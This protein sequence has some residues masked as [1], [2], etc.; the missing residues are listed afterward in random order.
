MEKKVF[1]VILSILILSNF[2]IGADIVKEKNEINPIV[3]EDYNNANYQLILENKQ[4]ISDRF[5]IVVPSSHWDWLV[6]TDPT[7]IEIDEGKTRTVMFSI[8]PFDSIEKG[9]YTIP[10][11]IVSLN[12]EEYYEEE[13]FDVEV[14]SFE[15][16]I[17]TE[18]KQPSEIDPS[19]D[20]LFKIELENNYDIRFKNIEIG[21]ESDFFSTKEAINISDFE[22]KSK[23]LV[24]NF[25]GN[26]REG[27]HPVYV[28]IFSDGKEHSS[29]EFE[30]II[31]DHSRTSQIG[32]S[33]EK[34]LFRSEKI[35]KTND[36]NTISHETIT[37][38]LSS[39]E[40]RIASFVPEP[41]SIVKEANFYT[42]TW[43][44][45]LNPGETRTVVIEKDYRGIVFGLIILIFIIGGF[46]SYR[47]KH[48]TLTKDILSI[49]S[50]EGVL[51][52]D[53]VLSLKNKS[54]RSI[55]N[56]KLLDTISHMVG[57]PTQ[58]SESKTPKVIKS[59]EKTSMLWHIPKLE[60]RQNYVV[61]YNVKIEH[62]RIN[63]LKIPKAAA[64][65]IRMLQRKIVYSNIVRPF[66]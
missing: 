66:I 57:E 38:K 62:D 41:D 15:T 10:I 35:E 56:L 22:K 11:K 14:I 59:H 8:K 63:K 47:K 43:E 55:K 18:L 30:M 54:R 29:Q 2:A 25:T 21:I 33:I 7:P 36:G 53:V 65:Y 40:M 13:K 50:K 60:G 49:K 64:K 23:N 32:A 4:N 5:R 46:Y 19:K 45:D 44:F 51:S 26:V 39:M 42:L 31:G 20:N 16:A 58:F 6:T 9:L 24:V 1:L 34:F 52:M 12:D 3:V 37:K 27:S 17:T 48:I 61:S 28:K